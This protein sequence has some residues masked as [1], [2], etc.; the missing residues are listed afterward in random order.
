MAGDL[1]VEF[2]PSC[3]LIKTTCRHVQQ[4]FARVTSVCVFIKMDNCAGVHL[5]ECTG[6]V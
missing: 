2:Q 6:T 5:L 3:H 4:I 1:H